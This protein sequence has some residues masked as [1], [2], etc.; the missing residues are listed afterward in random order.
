MQWTVLLK[1][2]FVLSKVAS[3]SA[4]AHQTRAY[5]SI[6][7]L[8]ALVMKASAFVV[9]TLKGRRAKSQQTVR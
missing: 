9:L 3:E 1:A 2:K 5:Q 6:V 4:M 8:A 7:L